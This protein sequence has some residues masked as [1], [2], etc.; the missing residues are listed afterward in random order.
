MAKIKKIIVLFD[1]KSSVEDKDNTLQKNVVRKHLKEMG[2]RVK[3][4]TFDKSNFNRIKKMG[5]DLVFNLVESVNGS[6][7]DIYKAPKFLEESGIRFTGANSIAMKTTTNKLKTKKIL[8]QNGIKT[9]ETEF[10]TDETYIF[11]PINEDASIGIEEDCV[12]RISTEEQLQ[13]IIDDKEKK[14][15]KKYFAERYIDGREFNISII[16]NFG[17]PLVL[18]PAELVFTNYEEDEFK[19]AS[20][21]AK[22]SEDS[23]QYKNSNRCFEFSVKDMLLL[24][25]LE[26]ICLKCW[27]IFNLTGYARVDFRVDKFNN[28]WVLEINANPCI[29]PDSGFIAAAQK[30][31]FTYKDILERIISDIT[32]R[33]VIYKS[34]LND[35]VKI[36]EKSGFFTKEEVDI[37]RELI[38]LRFKDGAEKSGYN[39]IIIESVGKVLGFSCFGKIPCTKSSFDLYWIVIDKK[40]KNLGLGKRILELTENRVKDMGGESIYIETSSTELY[41]P[42]RLFYENNGY[43]LATVLADFYDK[44]DDKNLYVKK[45]NLL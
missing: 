38:T 34:D 36:T 18:P 13:F 10:I 28:P 40:Y 19:I 45:F 8:S 32:F 31:G 4:L 5:Y 12:Y 44:N 24:K 6:G 21:S 22:W 39:F 41:K 20:Y 14:T 17:K 1:G 35:V 16:N 9:P 42:T 26:S 43:S 30:K 15:G 33:E 3:A 2:Y 29:S 37:T 25:S 27:D 23:N 7:D 11:K